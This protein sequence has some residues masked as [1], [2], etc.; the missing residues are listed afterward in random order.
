ME[1]YKYLNLNWNS[2]DDPGIEVRSH[3]AT[4]E[5]LDRD[6]ALHKTFRLTVRESF[7]QPITITATFRGKT[8]DKNEYFFL[9][10]DHPDNPCPSYRADQIVRIN[11]DF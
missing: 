9:S 1:S 10:K 2:V 3:K 8:I 4:L 5:E 6:G 11:P 7:G